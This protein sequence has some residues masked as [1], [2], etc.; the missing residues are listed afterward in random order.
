MMSN[1]PCALSSY[2]APHVQ[3]VRKDKGGNGG[4]GK[5]GPEKEGSVAFQWSD[6][7]V[8]LLLEVTLDYKTTKAA[9]SV[10]WESV[11]SKY[12]DITALLKEELP[13][14]AV[15]EILCLTCRTEGKN[16]P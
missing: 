1:S 9:E 7:E 13:E 8:R 15:R 14:T 4:K 10:D 2:Q 12:E 16:C 3:P 11:R 6:D 5:K